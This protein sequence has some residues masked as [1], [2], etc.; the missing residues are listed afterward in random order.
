MGFIGLC[1][2][3]I[4]PETQGSS[5][6]RF[7][8]LWC[9]KYPTQCVT[10]WIRLGGLLIGEITLVVSGF[11]H[12]L[13]RSAMS[14]RYFAKSTGSLSNRSKHPIALGHLATMSRVLSSRGSEPAAEA[15]DPNHPGCA[16][17]NQTERL[18]SLPSLRTL[19]AS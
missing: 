10:L 9:Q 2:L 4:F 8:L 15:I 16:A 18:R 1:I 13:P 12:R 11:K 17:S 3:T 19:D 7:V 14:V 5:C 6:M